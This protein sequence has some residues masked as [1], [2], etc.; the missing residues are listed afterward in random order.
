MS[1]S[2][3]RPPLNTSLVL[4][5]ASLDSLNLCINAHQ[6]QI[7]FVSTPVVLNGMSSM[8]APTL[9][10]VCDRLHVPALGVETEPCCHSR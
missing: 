8:L 2:S 1:F 6:V 5:I 7:Q 4:L 9:G 10:M 3:R